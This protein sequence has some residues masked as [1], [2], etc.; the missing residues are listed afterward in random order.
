MLKKFGE[1][2]IK[3][4]AIVLVVIGVLT[5][6][7]I[8]GT[9]LLIVN[10]NKINSDLMSYL[11]EDFDDTKGLAFLKDNFN[12]KGDA[13]LVVRGDEDDEDLRKSVAAVRKLPGVSR[14][15]WYD[16]IEA[17]DKLKETLETLDPEV[18]KSE[19]PSDEEME[20]YKKLLNLDID[21]D[22][23]LDSISEIKINTADLKET[24]KKE[25]PGE[26]NKYDYV[27]MITMNYLPSTQEAYDLLDGIKEQFGDREKASMGMTES[28]KTV[29]SD[30]LNDLPNFITYA[31]LAAILVLILMTPSF[32]DPA[33]IIATL[34]VSIVL[35]MGA[36]YLYPSISVI[37][38]AMSAVLQLAITMDYSIF[39]MHIYKMRRKELPPLD[40]TV[41]AL[42]EVASS[43]TA[44][45]LTTIGGF[46]ALFFMRFGIGKDIASVI[47]K[48]VILSLAT[49]LILQPIMTF[50]L[51]KPIIKTTHGFTEKFNRK[52]RE[53]RPDCRG[54]GSDSL[55]EP[56]ARL[57]VGA[58]F[59][60]AALAAALLVPCYIGQSKLTFSYFQMYKENYDTPEK[61]LARDLG[62]QMIMAVPL[63]PKNG[64]THAGFIEEVKNEPHGKVSSVT[65]AF[66][67]ITVDSDALID[68]LELLNNKTVK[69]YM[70]GGKDVPGIPGVDLSAFKNI[71]AGTDLSM[72]ESYFSLVGAD[73]KGKG[74]AWYT[75]Y[76]IG[77]SG[78]T[79]D[80]EAMETYKNLLD[81]REKYFGEGYSIGM[82][83]GSY[84]M[85]R[86]TPTDFMNVTVA[87][88]VII[89]VI[90]LLLLRNPLKSFL[91]VVLI[92]LGIWINL[93]FSYLAKENLNFMVYIII[94]SVQLGVTVDYA[95]LLA[96][97][98][99]HNRD[100]Y[101]SSR[102]CAVHSAREAIPAIFT[103]VLLIASVC[104]A[105]YFVSNNLIIK[106][107]TGMLARGAGI[108]FLLVMF[109]QTAALSFFPT[110]RRKIDFDGKIKKIEKQ[111]SK[112]G[113]EGE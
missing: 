76:T 33:I 113:P 43:I 1:A 11:P 98:F 99:E 44:S 58:R 28:A 112:N 59:L 54:F 64:L 70:D 83:T 53:K 88:A 71:F 85:R 42:P 107:L 8:V 47:I 16:D 17:L 72:L 36:N 65:G 37:S 92:E 75:L 106:Q 32:L 109:V 81:I 79:E 7:A 95:I 97:T 35:S 34:G 9:I 82:L 110:K 61:I 3:Y 57:S 48:G 10:E 89:F 102:D 93:T 111:L 31:V 94:S 27:I 68:L 52:L 63:I 46:A 84:D 26:G 66:T 29:M 60:L 5:A 108:A 105:V 56:A 13:M 38:F 104:L 41:K 86:V 21:V 87:S 74:G 6:L 101:K 78:S 14:L 69:N 91:L 12:I 103:S 49:I 62:N 19:L 100:K 30:T 77:I 25:V 40:A 90:I 73:E 22:R 4:K 50:M 24:M 39:Y 67:A 80:D 20:T 15:I 51:D 96:N 55:V 45:C 2:L 18:I 23:L